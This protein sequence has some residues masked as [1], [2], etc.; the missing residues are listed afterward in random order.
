MRILTFYNIVYSNKDYIINRDNI[1]KKLYIIFLVLC[2]NKCPS[3]M[4]IFFFSFFSSLLFFSLFYA[5]FHRLPIN[6]KPK[7]LDD[8]FYVL[9]CN[10]N[11]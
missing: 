2:T 3:S 7:P 4:W 8:S 10:E 6:T 5:C 11:Y 1:E 9:T